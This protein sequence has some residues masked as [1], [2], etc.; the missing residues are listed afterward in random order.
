MFRHLNTIRGLVLA[1]ALFFTACANA[2]EFDNH[3]TNGLSKHSFVKTSCK[4][5][6]IYKGKTYCFSSEGA[7]DSFLFDEQEM[8]DDAKKF[9]AS[10]KPS[11]QFDEQNREKITQAGVFHVA[12]A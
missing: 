3:C 11:K 6:E 8:I 7:R 1:S 4:I 9:Y 10:N 12:M 5:N 2:G